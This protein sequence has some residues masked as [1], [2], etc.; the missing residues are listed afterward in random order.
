MDCHRCHHR[1]APL[2]RFSNV[3]EASIPVDRMLS[4]RLEVFGTDLGEASQSGAVRVLQSAAS[5]R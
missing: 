2:G 4:V 1:I 5:F 3:R